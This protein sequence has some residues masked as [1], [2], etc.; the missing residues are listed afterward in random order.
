MNIPK[1]EFI[2][3]FRQECTRTWLTFNFVA[4]LKGFASEE[5]FNYAWSESQITL[6]KYMY[7]TRG[8]GGGGAPLENHKN[9]AFHSN[10]GSDPLKNEPVHWISNNVA[11]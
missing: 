9:I 10:T 3:H 7:G 6:Q 5:T 2:K 8:W 1:I 4:L 11:F